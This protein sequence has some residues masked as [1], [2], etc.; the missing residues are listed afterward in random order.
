MRSLNWNNVTA[1]SD[2]DFQR[3]PAGPY[4]ATIVAMEDVSDREYVSMVYD[5]FEGEH[6]GYYSDEWGKSHPNAHRVVLS[7]KERAL[8]MTKG[9]LEAIAASNPGFDPFAAW[10]A[11]RLDMFVGRLVGLNIREEE[12]EWDGETK[13]RMSA[14]QVLD[15]AKVRA[16]EV[17]VPRRKTLDGGKPA[18]S[19]PKV[20]PYNGPIPFD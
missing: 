19:T 9:R 11:G 7:Y 15:A 13:V 17:K 10:D 6:K 8:G 5:I 1:Q 12:Y 14:F 3:L 18:A 16:G 20:E 2:G 4:V